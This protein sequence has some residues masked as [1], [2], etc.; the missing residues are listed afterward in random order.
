M[1][2]GK[3]KIIAGI[4]TAS[5]I[6]GMGIN[7]DLSVLADETSV[8]ETDL[9]DNKTEAPEEW[10][11]TP[12][13]NQYKYQKEELA[14]FCHFGPNTYEGVEW[15]ENYGDRA[16]SDIFR[17]EKDFDADR[18]VQ[19]MQD[20]GFKK[21]II[22]AKHH[23]GFCLW[24]S[25]ETTYDIGSTNYKN[26]QGDILAELSAACTKY[27]LD[28]GLYLSPW[29]I[30]EPSYGYYDKDGN[31][32]TKDNDELD[33]NIHYN[34]QLEEILGNDKYGNDGHFVEVWMDGAKGSGANAQDYDFDLWFDTIQKHEGIAGGYDDDCLLF[35]AG[36]HTTVRWIGN[37]LG[38]A[39]EETWSKSRVDYVNNTINNNKVG[40]Y[41]MGW[42][43]GNQWTV[44]E[45]DSRITSGWF[46]TDKSADRK[47]PK[48][49]EELSN[50]YFNSV[51]HNAVL[52][53][54]IPPNTDGTVDQEILDRMKEFGDNIKNSFA[55]NL[56][57]NAVVTASE[58]R[59]NDIAFSPDNVL[60]GD[61]ATYWTME[62]GSTTGSLTL[63]LGEAQKF[64][65]VTMEEA[66]Q[67]GQRIKSFRIEYKLGNG[68]WKEFAEGT[69]IGAKRICRSA[70]VT[71]DKI[72]IHITDSYAVPLISEVGVYKA[73]KG[74]EIPSPIPEGMEKILISDT[75]ISDGS[76]FTFSDGWKN[77]TGN[78]FIDGVGTWAGSGKTAALTFT[79][80]K[81]WLF[82]TKD[83]GHGTADVYIDGEKVGSFD[84]R[85]AARATGQIIYESGDLD[86]G[87]HT[88]EIR[89]TGTVG[90]NAAAVLN[91]G[92][93]GLL[94]FEETTC[95]MME[96]SEREVVVKR[97]G[98]SSGE[99]SIDY[100][101]NPGSAVQGHY[102]IGIGG[103][104]TFKEGETEKRITVRTKRYLEYTGDLTF[105]LDLKNAKDAVLGFN[106][107]LQV[108]ITD[109][110]DPRRLEEAERLVEECKALNMELYVGD[111]LPIVKELT[112]KLDAYLQAGDLVPVSDVVAVMEQLKAAKGNLKVRE[113]YSVED[114]FVFPVGNE[115]KVLEAELFTLDSSGVV[116]KDQYVR[117]STRESASN[118]KEV[119]YFENGNRI[120]LP[121][122]AA[123]AG[124]YK[125]T[126]TY[127]SGR[128]SN[129]PNAFEWSGTN[130]VSGSQNVYGE[131]NATTYHTQEFNIEVSQAGDGE[132]VFTASSKGGPVI[133]KFEI[134][135]VDKTVDAVPVTGVDLDTANLEVYAGETA[136]ITANISPVD[137]TNQ[138]VEFESS[139]P[140]VVSVT[141]SGLMALLIFKKGGE[142]DIT[143]TTEDGSKTA[144]C[145]VSVLGKDEAL[146]NLSEAIAAV[147]GIYDAGRQC[148]I[149]ETWDDFTDAYEAAIA[150]GNDT[151]IR[152]LLDLIKD[153][154]DAAER[155]EEDPVLR[156]QKDL[157]DQAVADAGK[158]ISEGRPANVSETAWKAFVAAYQKVLADIKGDFTED[159]LQDLMVLLQEKK[160]SVVSGA[161]AL[162]A[163]ANVK[164]V[165]RVDGVAITFSQVK[166]AV[167]YEIYRQDGS[168]AAKKIATVSGGSYTDVNPV[169]GK[170]LTYTVIAA[171]SNDSYIKSAASAPASVT[172]PKSVSKLKVKAVSGG[173]QISFKKVKSAKK[174][175]ILRAA[176][177]DGPYKKI[178]VLKAKQTSYVDKKA[179]KGQNF[180]KVV[181][182]KGK[183]YSPATKVKKAN[184]KK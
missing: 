147:K 30:H 7:G 79:G 23:D 60:D 156:G 68:E 178:K 169:G 125:V 45:A 16:P 163:P 34:K 118:G 133:D 171:S 38:L 151:S 149:Q 116:N 120:I 160:Q 150:G 61:D 74:F 90:L 28:M 124:E 93:K 159:T 59:G 56:A 158:I 106:D 119:N 139:D 103:T 76:G 55:K 153:L 108:V 182:Q 113:T 148:Y 143:V 50:M 87:A 115:M 135:P 29:D 18:I 102:D 161:V 154:N 19:A 36:A 94:Q 15:G 51:G 53:L 71:A 84:T 111:A 20:A 129:N 62:D 92:Q 174:Y 132:L 69:T 140:E 37:E 166:N 70:A 101:N 136:F 128:A 48:T 43:D 24:Q 40:Q 172:L 66:I 82:G 33:Y 123:K 137:A 65:M 21:L 67:L 57:K 104:L 39:N 109:L 173:A 41:N 176:K 98:G 46:W 6:L 181:T 130:I 85:A 121:Y 162:S 126:A 35:G 1:Q 100:E 138:N 142:A 177:K 63:D 73:S 131:T 184:V 107:S 26:G 11:A 96:D 81:V 54:N 170:T 145:K 17:L 155:L 122:T 167:S 88:L 180:Y 4:L 99:V 157:L 10:G 31:P 114:P 75:D 165:S 27:D 110:E 141:G 183:T 97:V 168:A 112:L 58:V 95:T 89:T 12:S 14:A 72:R 77:E 47:N 144:S 32:T 8:G 25:A 83:P 3:Q 86:L 127:R 52:L 49:L 5:M 9:S 44:P 13:P 179:K 2:K 80:H 152:E 42:P 164:A 117:I 105:T 91:N 78:Q 146:K 175:I 134:E 64:D 22:T